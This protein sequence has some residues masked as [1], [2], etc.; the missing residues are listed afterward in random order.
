[1]AK[2][3]INSY[4][5]SRVRLTKVSRT[6]DR[7]EIADLSIDIKLQGDFA[8]SYTTGDNRKVIATDSMKNTVYVLAKENSFASIED[9]ATL[10][11][12]HFVDTYPQVSCADITMEESKWRR[13]K[14]DDKPHAHAF[15]SCGPEKRTC[16]LMR[17]RN[18]RDT[19]RM[20]GLTDLQVLKTAGS[21]F[22]NF[23]TD[24]YRTLKDAKDRIFATTIEA[25]WTYSPDATEFNGH[26][27][28]IRGALLQTFATHYSLAVQQTLLTM[29]EAALAACQKI[30]A[31]TLKLPNQHRIPFNLQPFGLENNNE[32]FV[33]TDEPF[34]SISGTVTRK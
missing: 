2:L 10:L 31:I 22:T 28:D 9:F 20:G 3:L 32:I 12:N 23:V 17:N 7:H 5:K 33:T 13:I 21:E 16:F 14:T 1:L 19:V 27:V 6:S 29:G 8:A 24:R 11:S 26:F 25:L 18:L 15:V 4:G 34:G 30:D